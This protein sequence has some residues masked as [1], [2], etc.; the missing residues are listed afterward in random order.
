M[1]KEGLSNIIIHKVND[2]RYLSEINPNYGV[3]FD[4]RSNNGDLILSHD[5]VG[6]NDELNFLDDFIK[7][8]RKAFDCKYKRSWHRGKSN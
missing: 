2:T 7:L 8:V 1:T 5:P 3:E 4:V 6:A